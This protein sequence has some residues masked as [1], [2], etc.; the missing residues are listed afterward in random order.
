MAQ[1]GSVHHSLHKPPMKSYLSLL[2]LFTAVQSANAG[3]WTLHKGE[4][5]QIDGKIKGSEDIS[6]IEFGAAGKGLLAS[7]EGAKI[8]SISFQVESRTIT[9]GENYR[10]LEGK[11]EAD[12]E[13]IAVAPAENVMYATGSHA[14]SRKKK[15]K[16]LSRFHIFRIK[17][18]A[19]TGEPTNDIEVGSLRP[20]L[21]SHSEFLPFLDRP[22]NGNGVD[23]EGLA[24]KS[25]RL[26]IGFRAPSYGENAWI[27]E[28]SPA[29]IFDGATPDAKLHSIPLGRSIGVRSLT[30]I[31]DG[32][33][34]LSG[35]SG[36]EFGNAPPAI[37]H[38]N[39][40]VA[41]TRLG[42]IPAIESKPEALTV[43]SE[44]D[45]TIELLVLSDGPIGGSPLGIQIKKSAGP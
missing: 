38:W 41:T 4:P 1:A 20:L 33:L 37:Y 9:V 18:D 34:L 19:T 13:G 5:W 25:G 12:I 43:I 15:E 35:D 14:L 10:L 26:F 27:M 22:A 24:W 36:Q 3:D 2:L 39:P 40:G 8:Q 16:E 23:I 17:M 42:P 30:A 11:V 7:D 6:A 21:K 45:T 31:K 29:A 32:F 44:T 28:V